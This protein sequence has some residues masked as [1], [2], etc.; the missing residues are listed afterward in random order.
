[1]FF[2]ETDLQVI[3][4]LAKIIRRAS[5]TC[6]IRVQKKTY[7]KNIP[8]KKISILF[9]RPVEKNIWPSGKNIPKACWN[10]I[11]R[12]QRNNLRKIISGKKII[13][14]RTGREN[15]PAF[16]QLFFDGVVKTAFYLS[17]GT[18]KRNVSLWIKVFSIICGQWPKNFRLFVK[19]FLRGLSKLQSTCPDEHFEIK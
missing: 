16:W 11:L 9:F 15:F 19:I 13:P 6:S 18:L 17:S 7:K 10:Y 8:W 12:V 5:Q 3:S 1:M 14:S 4:F 2:S